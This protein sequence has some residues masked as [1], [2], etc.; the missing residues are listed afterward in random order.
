MK[1]IDVVKRLLAG[2][3]LEPKNREG[4]AF[5]PSNIALCKYW[6]KRNDELNLPVTS[7]LSVSLGQLGTRTTIS[8]GGS[9]DIVT[10]NGRPVPPKSD[11]AAG[12]HQFL[13]LIQP[14]RRIGFRV[15]THNSIPTA[16]GLASSASGFA[17]LALALDNLFGW[18]LDRK[19]LS[20]LSRLGS[21]SASRSVYQG[22]AEW[23]AGE[24]ADGMD[25]FA[26]PFPH[27]WPDLRVGLLTVSAE[28]KKIGSREAMKR[29]KETST[30]Y[31]AWPAKVKKDLAL[32]RESIK[33][34]D[35]ELL[36]RVAESN[37]LTMHATSLGAWPP[38]LFWLPESVAL[39]HKIWAL[40]E[41]GLKIYFT[42]DAGPNLK[43]L[44]LAKNSRA[45]QKHFPR[46]E[47]VAPFD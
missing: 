38:V 17:A 33:A 15:D 23:Y 19:Q 21:G 44:F 6:G 28:E 42:M 40:R 30:L 27:P 24:R 45:V 26:E 16:A 32:V 7:S 22:F 1:K 5:A 10:L 43:L 36:G 47:I 31:T 4:S 2:R 11:F 13:H 34:R 14:G 29:T 46:V 37:A 12:V 18:N 3:S 25:S 9:G 41:D 20:I 39:M 8:I 35:F